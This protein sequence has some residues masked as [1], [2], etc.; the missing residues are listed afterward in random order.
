MHVHC[1][2]IF[3]QRDIIDMEVHNGSIDIVHNELPPAESGIGDC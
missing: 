3:H 1:A 2:A